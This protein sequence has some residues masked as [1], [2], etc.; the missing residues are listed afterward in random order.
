M[1]DLVNKFT[2]ALSGI[3][4]FS[5]GCAMALL[6]FVLVGILALFAFVSVGLAILASP[7][8]AMARAPEDAPVNDETAASTA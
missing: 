5:I 6:G 8:V 7:F 1:N 2:S 3:A 4:L